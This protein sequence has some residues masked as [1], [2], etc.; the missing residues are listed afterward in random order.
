MVGACN[1]N[2]ATVARELLQSKQEARRKAGRPRLRRLED[3]E[4]DFEE[5]K[6]KRWR[7]GHTKKKN[8]HLS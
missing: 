1:R 7:K 5:L 6:V 4:N 2:G 8:G 3:S